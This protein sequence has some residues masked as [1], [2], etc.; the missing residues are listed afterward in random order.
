MIHTI[1]CSV[2]TL[3]LWVVFVMPAWAGPFTAGNLVVSRIGDGTTA[4]PVGNA[5]AVFLDEYTILGV[6]AGN[7]VP[8]P[9]SAGA[10]SFALTLPLSSTSQ[11][12]LTL[13]SDSRF[14]TIAGVDAPPNTTTPNSNASFRGR[15]IALVNAL[16]G[17]DSTTRFEAAGTSARSAA[18]SDGTALWATFDSGSGSPAPGGL[19]YAAAGA[20]SSLL[21]TDSTVTTNTRVVNI[22]G[23]SLYVSASSGV[24]SVLRGVS[25]VSGGLAT[26]GGQT[27]TTVVG[28]GGNGT[29]PIDSAYDFYF[30]D[31]N[32]LYVA[33]DDNAASVITGGLQKWTFDGTSWTKVWTSVPTGST[34]IRSLTGSMDP[35]GGVTI[36]AITSE[37]SGT[38]A[39]KLVTLFDAGSS[40]PSFSTLA[41]AP[42][43]TVFRGVDFAPIPEPATWLAMSGIALGIGALLAR[44]KKS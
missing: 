5:N 44:R 17:V 27:V 40:I 6:P 14:L 12:Q 39:N 9:T 2:T 19:R 35:A 42:T 38:T 41:T 43:N 1:R 22:F 23:G 25:Q 32:T 3:V 20:A 8:L 10:G 29:G 31:A 37:T 7:S 18:T 36:Y 34:G 26:T 33:D 24:P 30:A 11:G 16:G 15:T 28:G 4:V 21:L 13:S